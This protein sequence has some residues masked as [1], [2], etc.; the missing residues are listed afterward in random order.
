MNYAGMNVFV[1]RPRPVTVERSW[2]E[3]WFSWPWRPWIATK[4]VLDPPVVAEDYAVNIS[5]D[6][7]CSETIYER[8][9]ANRRSEDPSASP[10]VRDSGE[11]TTH[12]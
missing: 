6:L 11:I 3:R 4:A 12:N 9:R 8:L 10:I 2:P 7:F 1:M 5:N